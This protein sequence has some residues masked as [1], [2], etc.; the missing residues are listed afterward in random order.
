MLKSLVDAGSLIALFDKDDAY[1]SSA[2]SFWEEFSGRLFTS[3][4]VVTEVGHLL[5]FNP[6][7]QID[8]LR[9]IQAGG[10]VVLEFNLHFTQRLVELA[11]K[12]QDLPMDFADGSLIVLAEFHNVNNIVTVESDFYV[13]RTK[14]KQMLANI[15]EP[16][17]KKR[18][19][20]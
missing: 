6:K 2:L 9:W 12:Y 18:K 16:Y 3:W 20:K 10:V 13:R 7:A 17:V 4:L 1:H 5:K 19:G 14:K 11:M 8:F 15:F